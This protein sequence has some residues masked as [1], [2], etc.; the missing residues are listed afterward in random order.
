MLS[1]LTLRFPRRL[2]ASLKN[3]AATEDTSVN[4][5]A[6]RLLESSLQ[7][8]APDSEYR[9]LMTSPDDT[10]RTLYRKIVLGETFGRHA[11]TRAE[12]R[13]ILVHAHAA[14]RSAPYDEYVNAERVRLMLTVMFEILTWQAANGVPVDSHYIRG[15]FRFESEDWE[16]EGK[17]FL[18]QLEP[19]I[20]AGFAE[21]LV[22]PFIIPAFGLEAVSEAALAAIFSAPRLLQVFPL[23]MQTRDWTYEERNRFAEEVRP[24][25]FS[26]ERS[27]SAGNVNIDVRVEGQDKDARALRWY[28]VP[29]LFVL[30]SGKDFMMPF[31]WPH[32][33]GLYRMLAA[34]RDAP[35]PLT[36]MKPGSLVSLI[37]PRQEGQDA[38]VSFDAL[39][40]FVPLDALNRLAAE[41]TDAM[42]HGPLADAVTGLRLLYGD[43]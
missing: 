37:L 1:Q 11:L 10:V 26:T 40:V 42:D 21:I 35:A 14:Y 39:R 30:I 22:R 41:L 6:E 3:R 31:E 4:A 17:Q 34:C 12:L 24:E 36:T 33:A 27:F 32:L 29:R 43:L 16:S 19:V 2:I 25:I 20:T 13:F 9:T 15:T 28:D 5:L 23:V 38:I 7:A 18:A 8:P